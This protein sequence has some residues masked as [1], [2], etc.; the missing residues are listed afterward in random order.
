[1]KKSDFDAT[2]AFCNKPFTVKRKTYIDAIRDDEDHKF[3]CSKECQ[4]QAQKTGQYIEC[5]N[6]GKLCWKTPHDMK[7]GGKFCSRSC[8]AIFNNGSRKEQGKTTKGK[9]KTIKCSKCLLE[10]VS[11]IHT[12]ISVNLCDNCRDE[13][14]VRER[15]CERCD[16]IFVGSHNARFCEDCRPQV[17]TEK[18]QKRINEGTLFTKSIKCEYIFN[19]QAI[20]CDS[21]LE[22][23]CLLFFHSNYD[24][25][26]MKRAGMIIPYVMDDKNRNYFPDFEITLNSGIKYLVECKGIVG[27]KLSV[28]WNKYNK[29]APRKK[30]ALQTWCYNNGY[31]PFW[32][33]LA[34]H[35]SLYKKTK[36][37]RIGP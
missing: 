32:F 27:E 13:V 11:S 1:M 23:V 9:T 25:V 26:D 35:K 21:K 34:D 6:C 8:A 29:T 5:L 2:C 18:M 4:F 30:N 3:Y 7:R 15:V 31:I 33:D 17:I 14:S 24:V 22:Y 16:I 19:D 12:T 20:R 28:K 36:V 37:P 10:Y